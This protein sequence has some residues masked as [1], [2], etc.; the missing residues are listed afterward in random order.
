MKHVRM[1]IRAD[2]TC[3][4]DAMEFSDS[5]CLEATRQIR[6][7]LAGQV[8]NERRKAEAGRLAPRANPRRERTL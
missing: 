6:Q 5:T 8:I 7:A 2:G 1:I 3:A 4:V